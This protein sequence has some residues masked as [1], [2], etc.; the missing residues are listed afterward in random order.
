[1]AQAVKAR[2]DEMPDLLPYLKSFNVEDIVNIHGRFLKC[3]SQNGSNNKEITMK[4]TT[5]TKEKLGGSWM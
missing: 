4:A 1:M 2:T 5:K 3:L